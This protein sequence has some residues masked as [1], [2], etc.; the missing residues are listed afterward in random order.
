MRG[1]TNAAAWA[2]TKKSNH[3]TTEPIVDASRALLRMRSS[4]PDRKD[5]PPYPFSDALHIRK[6]RV[7]VQRAAHPSTTPLDVPRPREVTDQATVF[8]FSPGEKNH[9]PLG[10]SL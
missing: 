8:A 5:M 1:K 7:D 4:S 3:S 2:K 9:T 6:E 10:H